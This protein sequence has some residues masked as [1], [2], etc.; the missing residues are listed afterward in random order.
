[1]CTLKQVDS[2]SNV[3][4]CNNLKHFYDIKFKEYSVRQVGGGRIKSKGFGLVFIQLKG[5][6]I[7]IP[8]YPVYYFPY[9]P[10][11]TLSPQILKYYNGYKRSNIEILDSFSLE[12]DNG[13]KFKCEVDKNI[14]HNKLQD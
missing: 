2:G 3:H 10:R 14:A 6:K 7:V 8:L 11:N 4:I 9:N 13:Y 5:T 12:H 1:M